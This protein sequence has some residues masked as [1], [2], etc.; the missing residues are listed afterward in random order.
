VERLW[1]PDLFWSLASA[2]AGDFSSIWPWGAEPCGPLLGGCIARRVYA[3]GHGLGPDSRW[4]AASSRLCVSFCFASAW[5]IWLRGNRAGGAYVAVLRAVSL[6]FRSRGSVVCGRSVSGGSVG[7]SC[8]L[9]GVVDSRSD[10]WP[11]TA[12][13]CLV[14]NFELFAEGF[15]LGVSF[16]WLVG[17][18]FFRVVGCGGLGGFFV[19]YFGFLAVRLLVGGVMCV[20]LSGFGV[21]WSCV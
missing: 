18:D 2:L 17:V 13:G 6:G 3:A 14:L 4:T 5:A 20:N 1:Y 12:G 16:G 15:R 10:C 9:R 19:C 21:C 7:I 11:E 8:E